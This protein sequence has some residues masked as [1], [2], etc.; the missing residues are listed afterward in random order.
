MMILDALIM[1]LGL[2]DQEAEDVRNLHSGQNNQLRLAHYPPIPEAL[3]ANKDQVRAGEHKDGG[4]VCSRTVVLDTREY[5]T[6]TYIDSS[7]T[8]LFQDEH[9]GLEFEDPQ[10]SA[11]MQATPRKGT[12]YLNLGDMFVRLSNGEFLNEIKTTICNIDLAHNLNQDC[13][14]LRHI[15]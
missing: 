4:Y 9:P 11:S 3:L 2:S 5:L 14:L 1:S 15:V 13:T 12:L 10:T 7:F 8:L 6:L